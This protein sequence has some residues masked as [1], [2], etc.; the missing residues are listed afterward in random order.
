MTAQ[1][2]AVADPL[3]LI[4]EG[5]PSGCAPCRSIST[6]RTSSST[7]RTAI[8]SAVDARIDGDEGARSDRSSPF[9]VANCATLPYRPG[10]GIR[11]SG[12]LNRR[13]HPAI[14]ADVTSKPGEANLKQ[15]VVTLPKGELLDNSH[16]G[17]VCT[18]VAFAQDACPPG[19]LVGRVEVTSPLLDDPLTGSVYL[20]SSQ[21][22]LPDLALDLEGQFD[23]E[24]VGQIDSVKGR[25]RTT[26]NAIPD[27]PV[28]RISFDLVGGSKGLLQN[29]ETLCGARKVAMVKMTGQ[30]GATTKQRTPLKMSC[31]R[32]SGKAR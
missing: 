1:V 16:I 29:S 5:I 32:Q 23:I 27:V 9:Q 4:L 2:T 22:K 6:D 30:N 13:G 25:F 21:H 20:R 28:S 17:T 3:P 14:H 11:L 31:G 19:A 15:V 8:G 18:R 10:L 26:F 24:A 7:R 12:G